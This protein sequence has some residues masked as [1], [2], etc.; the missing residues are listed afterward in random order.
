MANDKLLNDQIHE[1]KIILRI[2]NEEYKVSC[3]IGKLSHL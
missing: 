1:F 3:L 2:F